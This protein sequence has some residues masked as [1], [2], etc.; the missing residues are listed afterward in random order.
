MNDGEIEKKAEERSQAEQDFLDALKSTNDSYLVTVIIC[1][2]IV[3]L[4]IALAVLWNTFAGLGLAIVAVLLYMLITKKILDKNLGISYRSTSGE[5]SVVS[6][7][8]RGK[9]EIFVPHRLLWLDVTEIDSHAFKHESAS[10]LRT[11]H[12]PST[13]KS[14]GENAFEDCGALELI[15]FEGSPEKWD[16]IE[17]SDELADIEIRF[18]DTATYTLPRKPKKEKKKQA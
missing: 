17:K 14:I 2:A 13:I 11:V 18:F 8:A 5:L 1:A 15:C 7:R 16:K 10:N 12:L 4:G 3:A 6:Y 9:E